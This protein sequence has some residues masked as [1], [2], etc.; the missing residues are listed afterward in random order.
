M[1]GTEKR[2]KIGMA[3]FK[4][5]LQAPIFC[6]IPDKGFWKIPCLNLP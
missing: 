5:S 4:P 6:G 2:E 1:R 3:A